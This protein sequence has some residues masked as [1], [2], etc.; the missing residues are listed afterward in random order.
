MIAPI[1]SHT[2]AGRGFSEVQDHLLK[3]I[4]IFDHRTS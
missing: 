1:T 4:L 2:L 3:S